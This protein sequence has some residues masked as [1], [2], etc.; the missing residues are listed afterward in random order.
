MVRQQEGSHQGRHRCLPLHSR[1]SPSD[2]YLINQ[3][4]FIS[5]R[6]SSGYHA[7]NS[8]TPTIVY[9]RLTDGFSGAILAAPTM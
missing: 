3:L 4:I 5:H 9:C 1:L 2:D 6:A 7:G 8:Y